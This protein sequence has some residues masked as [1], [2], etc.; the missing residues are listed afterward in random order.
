[1]HQLGM[2]YIS[3]R[4]YGRTW[5]MAAMSLYCITSYARTEEAKQRTLACLPPLYKMLADR[6]KTV[7]HP[8]QWTVCHQLRH[9]PPTY[10]KHLAGWECML[11]LLSASILIGNIPPY[12]GGRAGRATYHAST[13]R[14]VKRYATIPCHVARSVCYCSVVQMGGSPSPMEQSQILKQYRQLYSETSKK[15]HI[16]IK[17]HCTKQA[18]LWTFGHLFEVQSRVSKFSA[19]TNASI[20]QSQALEKKT[21]CLVNNII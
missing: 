16:I 19:I 1:M 4:S 6:V 9:Q 12:L 3:H 5:S 11:D 18:E 8:H 14:T 13:S 17:L 20:C 2:Q 15:V 21:S 7:R 10:Y